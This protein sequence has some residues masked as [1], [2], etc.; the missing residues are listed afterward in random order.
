MT[1]SS[2]S[3]DQMSVVQFHQSPLVMRGDEVLY[4]NVADC[5]C[6]R[7]VFGMTEVFG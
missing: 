5:I 4:V 3:V 1:S 6:V 2:L 7:G